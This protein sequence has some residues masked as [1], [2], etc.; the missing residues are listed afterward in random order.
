MVVGLWASVMGVGA[1]HKWV[2]FGFC[3]VVIVRDWVTV[4]VGLVDHLA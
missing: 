4:G 2:G 1:E 3:G